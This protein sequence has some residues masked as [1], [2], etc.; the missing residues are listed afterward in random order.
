MLTT[1]AAVGMAASLAL[2]QQTTDTTFAVAAGARLQ[3]E[4]FAG[5]VHVRAWDRNAVRVRAEHGSG[6]RI[7]IEPSASVV[8]VRARSEHGPPPITSFEL[9]V[10]KRISLDLNTPFSDVSIEG[11]EGEVSVQSVEGAITVVGGGGFISVQSVEGAVRVEG[12]RGRVRV[13]AV[14]ESVQ[15]VRVTGEVIVQAIDGDVTLEGIDSDHVEASS[16]DG[17]IHYQ[18]TI[19]DGGRYRFAT[20]DGDIVLSVPANVNAQIT[21]ATFSGEF[22]S[23]FPVVLKDTGRGKRFSFILGSGSAQVELQAFD[24]T[25]Q[26]RRSK[27]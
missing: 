27:P 18:G 16:V 6:D 20:H 23:E 14:D 19:R 26:L 17:S 9:T 3:V 22:E 4:N 5:E 8:R 13:N 12:S 11:T 1:M 24:G 10:P 7:E 21:I 2:A 15:V 25:I